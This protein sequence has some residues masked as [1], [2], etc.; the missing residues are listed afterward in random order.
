[1]IV[2]DGRWAIVGGRNFADE[3][4]DPRRWWLDFEVQLEGEA[5][6]DPSSTF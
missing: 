5:V 3:Y 1:M 6:W 2:V 4:F